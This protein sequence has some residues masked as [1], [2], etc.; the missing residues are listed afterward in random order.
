MRF[1]LLNDGEE[2]KNK[3]GERCGH[4]SSAVRALLVL[5]VVACDYEPVISNFSPFVCREFSPRESFSDKM[6]CFH[7]FF[8]TEFRFI[9]F[10]C[11]FSSVAGSGR[12]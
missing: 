12:S 7:C 10:R 9:Y 11:C 4:T 1:K 8:G 6:I 5:L 3:F 2:W